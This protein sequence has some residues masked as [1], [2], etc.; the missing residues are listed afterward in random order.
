MKASKNYYRDILLTNSTHKIIDNAVLQ[1]LPADYHFGPHMHS[2][3]ELFICMEGQC[4]MTI[5]QTP[6][7]LEKEDYIAILSNHP[8]SCDTSSQ[9]GCV[10]L[11]LHFHPDIFMNLFSDTLKENHLFF[12]LELS[13]DQRKYIQGQCSPQ[14]YD[15]L[16]FIR[17]EMDGKQANYQKMVDLYFAQLLILISRDI[18][19]TVNSS[20]SIHSNRHLMSAFEYL[21]IHYAEKFTVEMLA[22]YC[23]I[24]SRFLSQLFNKHLGM[25]V[26][27]YITYFRINKSIELMAQKGVDYPLTQLALDV[28]FGSL[29][30]YSKVFKET[31]NISPTKYFFR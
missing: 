4:T 11:Q 28:G 31:M 2:T 12:L 10:I 19:Q 25:N 5:Y 30:H 1:S 22:K 15:C 8:H 6:V 29:Q 14:L 16:R 17:E 23:G 9:E 24:S 20:S 13:L 21:N 7:V 26:S 27:T 18:S 3:V